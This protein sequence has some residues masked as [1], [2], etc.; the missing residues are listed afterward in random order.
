MAG[1]DSQGRT[2]YREGREAASRFFTRLR[3]SPRAPASERPHGAGVSHPTAKPQQLLEWLAALV[4]KPGSTVLDA[5]SGSGAVAE[6][7]IRAGAGAV[8]AIEREAE[9]VAMV[10]ARIEGMGG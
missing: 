5:F 6:A 10:R 1:I 7:V 9:Y 3:Y 8:T 4:V 2:K